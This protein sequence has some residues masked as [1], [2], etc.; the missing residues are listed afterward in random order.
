MNG[1]ADSKG[2][3]GFFN[4]KEDQFFREIRKRGSRFP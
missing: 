1:I 3:S 4:G 2:C